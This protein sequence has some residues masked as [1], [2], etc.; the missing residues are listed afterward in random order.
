LDGMADRLPLQ[1]DVVDPGAGCPGAV[2][3]TRLQHKAG[4]DRQSNEQQDSNDN[5]CDGTATE[6]LVLRRGAACTRVRWSVSRSGRER[7][8]CA[9]FTSG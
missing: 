4:A 3:C 5:G 9:D 8:S 2:L 6:P 1:I 7:I